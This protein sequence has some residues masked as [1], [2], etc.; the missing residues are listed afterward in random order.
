MF[1]CILFLLVSET[2]FTNSQTFSGSSIDVFKCNFLSC[3]S[4]SEGGALSINQA[5][6]VITLKYCY[7]YLCSSSVSNGA[8][9]IT[10]LNAKVMNSCFLRCIATRSSAG[11]VTSSTSESKYCTITKCSPAENPT[12]NVPYY[13]YTGV[14]IISNINTTESVAS[15]HSGLHQNMLDNVYTTHINVINH[16]MTEFVY[17]FNNVKVSTYTAYVNIINNTASLG[18]VYLG[19]LSNANMSFFVFKDNTGPLTSVS[20]KYLGSGFFYQSS[21]DQ[22]IP[23]T[24]LYVTQTIQCNMGVT[25]APLYLDLIRIEYCQNGF[26][27]ATKSF[28]NLRVLKQLIILMF[29][30]Q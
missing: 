5:T 21:F 28:N 19:T 29:I 30:C 11:T 4:S 3:S 26:I 20:T 13:F 14:Q 22:S 1:F 24:G 25:V 17:G 16:R 9:V 10:G 8:I 23:T 2:T 18:L 7:F 6:S 12:T 15:H 27:Y